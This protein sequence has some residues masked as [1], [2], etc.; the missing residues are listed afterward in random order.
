MF[1][2]VKIPFLFLFFIGNSLLSSASSS[3]DSFSFPID[4][5]AVL[6]INNQVVDP[7][8]IND[9]PEGV[10]VSYI[11]ENLQ[12]TE[13]EGIDL[14][15]IKVMDLSNTYMSV[16]DFADFWGNVKDKLTS[17]QVLKVYQVN[18][19]DSHWPSFL[20]PLLEK[21]RF[22]FLDVIG[23]IYVNGAVKKILDLGKERYEDRWVAFSEKIIF[24]TEKYSYDLNTR[25]QWVRDYIAEEKLS[26]C[27][28]KKHDDYYRKVWREIEKMPPMHFLTSSDDEGDWE[29]VDSFDSDNIEKGVSKLTLRGDV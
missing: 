19:N 5:S 11:L 27:W 1:S 18:I 8:I 6:R 15:R 25:V 3:D 17:L 10:T 20:F 14:S 2:F 12:P 7:L 16:S 21:D 4:P 26:P 24:S 9:Y 28:K 22:L 13:G 29:G 23:T